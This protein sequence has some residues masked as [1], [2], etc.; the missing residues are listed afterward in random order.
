M[1]LATPSQASR[2]FLIRDA[3]GRSIPV[4]MDRDRITLGRSRASELFYPD[5]IGLSRQHLAL[6]RIG[7]QWFIEDLGSKNGTLLN[8][9]RIA[10]AQPFRPGDRVSAGHLTIEFADSAAPPSK[11]VEFV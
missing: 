9:E 2:G 3:E 8:G 11:T 6:Q 5:D 4:P 7:A 10:A 1:S